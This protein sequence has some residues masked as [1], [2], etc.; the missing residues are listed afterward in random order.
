MIRLKDIPTRAPE[1]LDKKDAKK[2]ARDRANQI[3]YLHQHLFAEK[4]H[5][6]LVV[7]QGMDSSGKDGAMRNVFGNCS[8][9]GMRAVGWKKPT[10]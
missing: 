3:S 5:S 7:L 10:E 9:F 2:I 4:K 6:V 8:P 1:A